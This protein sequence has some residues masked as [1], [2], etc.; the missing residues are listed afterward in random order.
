MFKLEI[1]TQ[2]NNLGQEN[3]PH[4]ATTEDCV[5]MKKNKNNNQTPFPQT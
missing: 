5:H 2:Q 4:N 3:P 1:V